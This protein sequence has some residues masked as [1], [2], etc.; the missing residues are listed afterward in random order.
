MR[1]AASPA[2]EPRPAFGRRKE[3]DCGRGLFVRWDGGADPGFGPGFGRRRRSAPDHQLV[4]SL[5]QGVDVVLA[6]PEVRVELGFAQDPEP[7][8][9]LP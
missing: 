4:I 3:L 7:V 6:G 2:R 1:E 5:Q 9:S 8:P